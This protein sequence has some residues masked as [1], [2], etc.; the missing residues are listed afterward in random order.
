MN[1][2]LWHFLAATASNSFAINIPLLLQK[3]SLFRSKIAHK[4]SHHT[5]QKSF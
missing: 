2:F 3:S 4:N 5:N 1:I